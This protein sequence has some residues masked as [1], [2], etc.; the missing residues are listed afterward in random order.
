[1]KQLKNGLYIV[2]AMTVAASFSACGPVADSD[3]T[4][5][6]KTTDKPI[7][8]T[9]NEDAAGL[10]DDAT[11]KGATEKGAMDHDT[12]D[13]DAT[14]S[15]NVSTTEGSDKNS[16]MNHDE[17]NHDQATPSENVVAYKWT[18]YPEIKSAIVDYETSLTVS[19]AA[20]EM[21]SQGT[22]RVYIAENGFQERIE[23]TTQTTTKFKMGGLPEQTKNEKDIMLKLGKWIYKWNP[24]TKIG[25]KFENTMFDRFATLTEEEVKAM[26]EN[27]KNAMGT[28]ITELGDDVVAT[29]NCMK[30]KSE[31]TVS[32][33]TS[34]GLTWTW[35]NLLLKIRSESSG[36]VSTETAIRVEENPVVDASLFQIPTDVTWSNI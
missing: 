35:K 24:E 28:K 14:S 21:T 34:V 27:L 31:T 36:T 9:K 2:M 6:D 10:I 20:V 18:P 16:E 7:V 32:G 8:E 13:K 4:N 33:I 30:V 29:M 23:T 19:Q 3:A 15:E 26:A 12:T 25:Y 17:M 5:A 1:M 22:K 11:D